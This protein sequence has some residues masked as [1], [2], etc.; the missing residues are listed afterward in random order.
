MAVQDL[1]KGEL[2]WHEKMNANMHSLQNDT[3]NANQ[4]AQDAVGAVEGAITAAREATQKAEQVEG[5]Y[6]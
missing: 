6:I 3:D 4:K 1:V 2:D 5:A